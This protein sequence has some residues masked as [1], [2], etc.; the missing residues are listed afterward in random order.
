MKA[1]DRLDDYRRW[2]ADE[3][4][5]FAVLNTNDMDRAMSR[6]KADASQ[7]DLLA[8]YPATTPKP[9][10]AHTVTVRSRRPGVSVRTR[11]GY[12]VP[13]VAGD[14]TPYQLSA[15]NV[16]PTLLQGLEYPA[17]QRSVRFTAT[18][19]VAEGPAGTPPTASVT[20]VVDAHD[21][22]LAGKASVDYAVIA[23][24]PDG[25]VLGHDVRRAEVDIDDTTRARLLQSGL[26]LESRVT[27]APGTCTLRVSVADAAT[28]RAGSLW[29]D[30]SVPAR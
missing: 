18:A 25:G 30:V 28:G 13:R 3:T 5:G 27:L 29:M 2:L 24:G 6:I 16:P 19:S 21:L 22:A 10:S 1:Q 26:H 8:Y 17:R 9:G 12:S 11:K 4:G 23:V 7:Y 15:T 20:L 14:K